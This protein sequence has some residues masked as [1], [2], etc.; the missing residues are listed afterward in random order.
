MSG[1]PPDEIWQDARGEGERRLRRS[2]G[3][4]AAT[5]FSGGAEVLLGLVLV[6]VTT[7][8]LTRT[9]G[10][11]GAAVV[12]AATF[13][14]GLAFITIGRAEL[15]TENFLIPVAAVREGRATL[16]VLLRMWSI[17]FVLNMV[18]IAA[19]CG[20]FSIHGVLRP[21]TLAAAGHLSDQV[22]QRGTGAALASAIIAGGVM[23]LFTWVAA[24]TENDVARILLALFVG[25]VL[26]A[27]TLN[28]A[29]VSFGE[30][31]FGLVAGTAQTA[32]AGDLVRNVVV[33]TAG[34]LVGGVLLVFSLRL[35]QV[36]GEPD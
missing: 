36:K 27:P 29:V 11:H 20:L 31:L 6:S 5:S 35:A 19:F 25:F 2:P 14:I 22:A 9:L 32:T 7:A 1:R 26:L 34:N 15:F 3:A 18:G 28:H 13:G 4:L 24:A 16:G 21:E 30:V 33:S 12:G 8:A 17:T 23:T 10:E